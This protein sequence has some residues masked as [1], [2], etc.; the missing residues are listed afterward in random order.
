MSEHE[1]VI[2][3]DEEA[4]GLRLDTFLAERLDDVSRTRIQRLIREGAILLDG[5]RAKPSTQVESGQAVLL[6]E[7]L[8]PPIPS[9]EP[10]DVAFTPLFED[11]DILVLDKPAG[12]VVHPAPGNWSGTLV[13]GLLK[14]WPQWRAPG[15]MP[16]PGIVHR[17]DKETS[18]L[19][20][21]ARTHR[22]YESLRRQIAERRVA[23]WYVALVWGVLP[24]QEGIIDRPIGR[25]PANR[26]RMAVLR[27]GGREAVT[28]W[29]VLWRFDWLTLVRLVLRT[30]RTHQIR[31][32][33]S[34]LG[35]PVFGDSVYGGV[36]YASRLS[37]RERPVAHGLLRSLGRTALHAYHLEFEHPADGERLLFESPVPPDMERVLEAI[38]QPGGLHEGQGR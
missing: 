36:R 31:V 5:A 23:R 21:V 22:A 10:E 7:D 26:Q 1:R 2:L 15:G 24:A 19:M 30:G 20:V 33:L 28:H 16:R 32:H 35:H 37:P 8:S 14:R 25:D 18:G 11:E 29:Q 3:V 4:E 9:V 27:R 38:Y 34:S 12:L 13:N 6:P 17:L